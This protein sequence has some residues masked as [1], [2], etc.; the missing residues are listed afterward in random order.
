MV[1]PP[2][3]ASGRPV[4]VATRAADNLHFIRATMERSVLFTALPGSAGLLLGIDG[5]VAGILGAR[6]DEPEEWLAVWITAACLGSSIGLWSVVR[7]A[8]ELS[9]PLT[10]GPARSFAVGLSVPLLAG[11]LITGE[12]WRYGAFGAMPAT[13]MLLYGCAL[14]SAGTFSL[15][16]VRAMGAAFFAAGAFALTTP[17]QPM[18]WANN[19][20]LAAVFGGL[21]LVFA[22][23]VARDARA[24]ARRV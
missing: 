23:F 22:F 9:V 16:Q 19:T 24:E 3:D 14:L 18:G 11:A 12:L 10:R 2:S 4:T 5:I 21:H 20:L 17:L 8:R 7:R 15:R 1:P 6:C 13:W